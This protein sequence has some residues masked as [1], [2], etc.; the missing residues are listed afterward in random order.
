M[1]TEINIS[2]ASNQQDW[3]E[4]IAPK[5]FDNL[6]D[7]NLLRTGLFGYINEVFGNATENIT[8][9][10]MSFYEEI[11]P[12]KAKLANSI[13]N[14]AALAQYED[15]HATPARM[16]FVMAIKKKDLID[17]ATSNPSFDGTYQFR[18]RKE[19]RIV[20][21]GTFNYLLD[22][23][24]LIDLIYDKKNSNYIIKF[25]YDMDTVNKNSPITDA[26]I[27]STS[28]NIEGNE[29]IIFQF[30]AA[31]LTMVTSE[32][33]VYE[34]DLVQ[35]IN[36]Q[37]PYEG[38]LSHFRVRYEHAEVNKS[39]FGGSN[40]VELTG[41]FTDFVESDDDYFYFYSF[42]EGYVDISFSA[43]SKYFR[44][45]YNSKLYVDIYTTLGEEGNFSY[46]GSDVQIYFGDTDEDMN[47]KNTVHV[48]SANSDSVG[49][50]DSKDLEEI[51]R[52][53]C[54][55]FSSR[56]NLIT[57][58]DLNELFYS[59]QKKNKIIFIKKRDDALMRLFNGFGIFFDSSES[60]IP[61][62]TND[63][64]VTGNTIFPNT[65]FIHSDE[66]LVQSKNMT[67]GESIEFEKDNP[68]YRCPFVIKITN[69]PLLLCT[70]YSTF[71]N[72]TFYM[73]YKYINP[74]MINQ[75]NVNKL[76]VVRNA[77]TSPNHYNLK[78][79]FST[80]LKTDSQSSI[81][82]L[83]NRVKIAAVFIDGGNTVGYFVFD[84]PTDTD[85]RG[86]VTYEYKLETNN[87]ISTENKICI[88]GIY[89]ENGRKN[90][91]Y[92]S[93]NAKIQFK[94]YHNQNADFT[95]ID[96]KNLTNYTDDLASV[97]E[98]A[99]TVQLFNDMSRIISSTVIKKDKGYVIRQVPLVRSLY[100]E[101]EANIV[102]FFNEFNNVKQI[103]YD[104]ISAIHENSDF[105]FK[106]FKTYGPSNYFW[107]G[108]KQ[109]KL[110]SNLNIS[111]DLTIE[112][113]DYVSSDNINE[114]VQ[115]IKQ[116]IIEFIES[117]KTFNVKYV[118]TSNTY[119]SQFFFSSLSK[120]LIDKFSQINSIDVV[121]LAGEDTKYQS[122]ESSIIYIDSM[123][124]AELKRYV[125][126]FFNIKK[127]P[128]LTDDGVVFTPSI[129]INII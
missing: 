77:I 53:S 127:E 81:E 82:D 126:E 116:Y 105:S 54:I 47:L 36:F 83:H 100:L 87:V 12:N 4:S 72:E 9:M 101:N 57:S 110:L 84:K 119:K 102:E 128:V 44:P 62:S 23:D 39:K 58:Q 3:L 70:Y 43:Y 17:T 120:S 94:V 29:F 66:Y 85:Y 90:D 1:N 89:D 61:T 108:R 28:Q 24:I 31:Q 79:E 74:I 45:K 68:I 111:L 52:N 122:I 48:L 22:Y 26:F 123:N 6:D 97:F 121:S 46:D 41:Y 104:N 86:L 27:K 115:E 96:G 60:I 35:N 113:K 112:F 67:V 55:A 88:K 7:Y 107:M 118:F 51:R 20:V 114:L 73:N 106:F 98:T 30:S 75:F 129:T 33:P 103:L 93:E 95:N 71:I 42:R 50:S 99:N 80:D 91:V 59:L 25:K 49:G 40:Q 14:N 5:K 76:E 8:F 13:Y 65:Q 124:K 16:S 19:N 21:D 38:Q 78:L 37:V 2:N 56:K 15:F 32:F 117:P 69:S 63:L 11:F 92:L 64:F 10:T 34:D 125:P 18:I 109:E